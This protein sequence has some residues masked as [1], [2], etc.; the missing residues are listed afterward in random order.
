V[1]D[2]ATLLNQLRIDRT[3][4]PGNSGGGMRRRWLIVLCAIVVM[5]LAAGVWVF[6]FARDGIPVQT[7]I[8]KAVAATGGS[9][10]A[11]G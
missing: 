6:A 4:T 8:A 1:D 3:Q 9:A 10:G 11:G 7:V 5:A 2:K